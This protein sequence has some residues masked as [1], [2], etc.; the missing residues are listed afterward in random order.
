M[1]LQIEAQFQE[2]WDSF[3]NFDFMSRNIF[4]FGF[5]VFVV[6]NLKQFAVSLISFCP[7]FNAMRQLDKVKIF[8]K[9]NY[10]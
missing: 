2:K 1:K 3:R 9:T 6:V 7:W 4:L 8:W 5:L 10:W